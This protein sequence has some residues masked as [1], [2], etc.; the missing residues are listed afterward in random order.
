MTLGRGILGTVFIVLCPPSLLTIPMWEIDMDSKAGTIIWAVIALLNSALY[1]W[2]VSKVMQ[3]SR[4]PETV[5]PEKPS[6]STQKAT[7]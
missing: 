4:T 3:R 6:E 5:P 1:A 2:F 7:I